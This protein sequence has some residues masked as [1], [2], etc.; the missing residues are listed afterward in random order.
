MG[1]PKRTTRWKI[2]F[3]EYGCR[4][5][6]GRMPWSRGRLAVSV[7][8]VLT[9]GGFWALLGGRRSW[10]ICV[11]PGSSSDGAE[12]K[13]FAFCSS[14][15]P[16]SFSHE[17]V[18]HLLLLGPFKASFARTRSSRSVSEML[19]FVPS[20]WLCSEKNSCDGSS[21]SFQDEPPWKFKFE[22][23]GQGPKWANHTHVPTLCESRHICL[24]EQLVEAFVCA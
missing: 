19:S 11:R 20:F 18:L 6:P 23:L 10:V 2:N 1:K 16:L 15:S 17:T 14:L 8:S 22:S 12:G 24:V 5:S 4:G 9:L 7:Q 13:G 21:P 3:L